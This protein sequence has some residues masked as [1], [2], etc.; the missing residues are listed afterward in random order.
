VTLRGFATLT[1]SESCQQHCGSLGGS[2][3][4]S[5]EDDGASATTGGGGNEGNGTDWLRCNRDKRP[6]GTSSSVLTLRNGWRRRPAAGG[7]TLES[8]MARI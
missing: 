8:L 5:V 4:Q 3:S 7:A 1:L 2:R 6:V